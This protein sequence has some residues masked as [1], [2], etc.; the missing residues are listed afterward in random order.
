MR[1][2]ALLESARKKNPQVA[3]LWLE[4]VRVEIRAKNKPAAQ[5]LMAS[6]LHECPK[7]GILWSESIFMEARPQRMSRGLDA[8]KR[9]DNSPFV[10]CTM[11]R[12]FWDTGKIDKARSWFQKA[13]QL[14]PDVGD[15]WAY[16]YKF[17]IQHGTQE[18]QEE[19]LKACSRA[20]PHHGEL[21][22]S[23]RKSIPNFRSLSPN[24]SR[25]PL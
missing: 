25:W 22:A 18:Q 20:D 14:N 9:T 10:I 6:A 4:A 7:S 3:E 23:I 13:V 15:F 17:E 21:W 8:L 12:V 16:Y 2:R 11:A 19:L 24:F 5:S 1:A